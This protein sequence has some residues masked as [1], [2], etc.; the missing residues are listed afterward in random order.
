MVKTFT[1]SADAKNSIV[2]SYAR[3]HKVVNPDGTITYSK[4]SPTTRR[5][6]LGTVP[7][8]RWAV[9]GVAG[10]AVI[11]V[12]MAS[13]WDRQQRLPRLPRRSTS[14]A[15]RI[16]ERLNHFWVAGAEDRAYYVGPVFF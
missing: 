3:R 13:R 9:A 12:G 15:V 11:L 16:A 7:L 6:T 4:A 14:V 2:G 10:L 8:G 1:K 5:N